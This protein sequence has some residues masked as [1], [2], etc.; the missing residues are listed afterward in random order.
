MLGSRLTITRK[1]ARGHRAYYECQ[2]SC[3]TVKTIRADNV[4]SGATLSCGCLSREKASE[5]LKKLHRGKDTR[6]QQKDVTLV[7]A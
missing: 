2:C 4:K 1:L 7:M 3:G 6:E 5:R